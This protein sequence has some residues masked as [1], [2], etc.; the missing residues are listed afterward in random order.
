MITTMKKS[1]FAFFVLK[2][3]LDI[4]NVAK[5]LYNNLKMSS[6]LIELDILY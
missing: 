5:E 1:A 6:S 3:I 2:V 4:S